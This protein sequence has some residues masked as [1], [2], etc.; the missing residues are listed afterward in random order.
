MKTIKTRTP[1]LLLGSD[2]S[3]QEPRLTAQVCGDP[4]MIQ[5]YREG[6]DLYSE[7]ASLSFKFPYEECLEHFPA[8]TPIKKVNDEWKSCELQEVFDNAK[9]VEMQSKDNR[10]SV[11]RH[12]ILETVNGFR[13]AQSISENDILIGYDGE[14]KKEVKVIK[15]SEED[16]NIAIELED[17]LLFKLFECN[18][19]EKLK[20]A[21]GVNDTNYDG[22][23]RRSQAKSILL[24]IL[25]GRQSASIAKQL[26]CSTEEAI[27]IR[28]S[29]YRE[30]PKLK[31]FETS[32]IEFAKKHGYVQTLWGRK[33]RLPEMKLDDFEFK[34][35]KNHKKDIDILDFT[36]EQS[37]KIPK[38]KI[39]YYT[40]LLKS[41]S[42]REHP[43]IIKKAL[44]DDNIIII[45][46]EEKKAAA[47][48][49]SVNSV[50]QGSAADMTKK[51]LL[52]ISGNERL[53]ELGFRLLVT[54]HDEFIGECPR[55]NAKECKELFA[56]A[57]NHCAD[58]KLTIP[59]S[60]DVV[61]SELWEGPT[62]EVD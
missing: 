15:V 25:Y 10:L 20:L 56:Y 12:F 29:V 51:A 22:K 43:K 49:K 60:C 11:G 46:N 21:D 61:V 23:N 6:K 58:D 8:G 3:A 30:F 18:D 44:Q 52:A 40:E 17:C 14:N 7:I 59:V 9:E 26:G 19:S 48:R 33:R 36:S 5:A 57:M 24:G 55:E 2:F 32:T 41:S 39:D 35:S 47:T 16:S 27:E 62:V 53:N 34:W 54:V 13:E 4:K 1:Y 50:I 45:S 37:D 31:E 28:E 42:W 38:Q